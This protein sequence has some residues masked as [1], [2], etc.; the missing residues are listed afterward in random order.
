MLKEARSERDAMLKE[1]RELKDKIVADAKQEADEQANTLINNAKEAI[2]TEKKA[3]LAEIKNE[4]ALMSIQIAEKIINKELSSDKQ[5]L[6]YV[7]EL[8]ADVKLK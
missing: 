2:E 1:A 4:V 5:Q 8:I 3:A 6:D 7:N